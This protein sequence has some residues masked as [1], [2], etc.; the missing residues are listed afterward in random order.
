M[1]EAVISPWCMG[2]GRYGPCAC[3]AGRI[4]PVI[5]DAIDVVARTIAGEARGQGYLDMIAVGAVIRERV[6]RPG[7]WGRDWESVCQKPWQFS[8]WN[9]GDPNREAILD[10]E[11]RFA[12]VWRICLAAALYTV[13]YMRDRDLH[14]LFGTQGPFPTHYHARTIKPPKWTEGAQLVHVPWDSAHLFYV[15][16][17]GTPRRAIT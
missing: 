10:A 17:E 13:R 8:C 4:D 3:R 2:C 9:E 14:E 16:V 1:S 5:R 11:R 6:L 12:G 7:W 15:G